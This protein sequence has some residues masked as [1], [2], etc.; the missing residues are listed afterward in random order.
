[1]VSAGLLYLCLHPVWRAQHT[2]YGHLLAT[3]YAGIAPLVEHPRRTLGL[4]RREDA[5]IVRTAAPYT[6]FEVT[7]KNLFIDLPILSALGLCSPAVSWTSR[8]RMLWRG[9]LPLGLVHFVGLASTLHITYVRAD[10]ELRGIY[11]S[12]VSLYV[13]APLRRVI[14]SDVTLLLPFVVWGALYLV[15]RQRG[16]GSS[17]GAAPRR[18]RR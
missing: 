12:A 9:Y 7:N 8:L 2:N 5:T 13:I 3:A 4:S 14:Y 6:D 11:P 10:A 16:R 1:V 17:A 18:G 15:E